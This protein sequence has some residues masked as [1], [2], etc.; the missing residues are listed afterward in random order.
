MAAKPRERR[1]EGRDG[2]R[3][4]TN[5]EPNPVPEEERGRQQREGGVKG[6]GEEEGE[7][8]R[9]RMK[10]EMLMS[11]SMSPHPLISSPLS[12]WLLISLSLNGAPEAPHQS[13]SSSCLIRP[14]QT[15]IA[16]CD[17]SSTEAQTSRPPHPPIIFLYKNRPTSNSEDA[18]LFL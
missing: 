4:K 15:A 18:R 14:I 13:H 17:D 2:E 11:V 5:P 12:M 1:R 7:R 3:K 16:T 6:R 9:G 10:D 8:T